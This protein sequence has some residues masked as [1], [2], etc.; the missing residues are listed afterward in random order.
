MRSELVI[1]GIGFACCV[2]FLML[3]TELG[4]FIASEKSKV[5]VEP[6]VRGVTMFAFRRNWTPFRRNNPRGSQSEIVYRE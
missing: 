6:F 5:T 2:Y 3:L 4:E 1:V